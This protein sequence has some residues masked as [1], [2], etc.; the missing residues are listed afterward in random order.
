MQMDS[1][2]DTIR[3]RRTIR[4]Y[5]DADVSDDQI[6][7]ILLAGM[8]APS[9]MDRRPWHFVVIRDPEARHLIA[10]ELRLHPQL[11][12]APVL[13]AVLGD[14][15]GSPTWRLDLSAA[16]E[17]ML[18]AAAGMGLGSAWIN[19]TNAALVEHSRI[20]EALCIPLHLAPF[21]IVAVGHAAETRPEHEM[22]PYFVST[23][24]HYDT[25]GNRATNDR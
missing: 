8:S 23:R 7:D 5:T 16:V 6:R 14:I 22:D 15:A 17:N 21:A 19:A 1:V 9:L 25:W 24:V 10:E 11:E 3:S 4:R 20:R 2:L 18:L 13:I 12:G